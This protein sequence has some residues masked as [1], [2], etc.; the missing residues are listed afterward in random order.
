MGAE[1]SS[2]TFHCM[3]KKSLFKQGHFLNTFLIE[4]IFLSITGPQLL[5]VKNFL[6]DSKK[7]WV[8]KAN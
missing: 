1:S 7:V 8:I 3:K 4:K 2:G 6:I 5:Y